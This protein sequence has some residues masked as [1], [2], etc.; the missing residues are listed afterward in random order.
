VNPLIYPLGDT[1]PLA[2]NLLQ[3]GFDRG[4][5]ERRQFSDGESYVR[6]ATPPEGRDV[7]LLCSL[8]GPDTKTLPLLFAADAAREQGAR[9]V[10]LAAPYLAYMR[11]DKA[12]HPGEAVTSQTYAKLLSAPFDWLV[13]L[14]PHLHRYPSLD[15]LYSIPAIA[16]SATQPIA[17]WVQQHVERPFLIGPDIESEQWVEA[18][19][20]LADAP[21]TVFH[22]TRKG[23]RD[24]SIEGT[25]API[26][27]GASPVIIDDIASSARTMI[28]AVRLLKG[29]NIPAPVCIA[30]HAL[31]A[32]DAFPKLHEAGPTVVVSTNSVAHP[33]NAIDIS[34]V[35]A[36][37]IQEALAASQAKP[38]PARRSPSAGSGS[39]ERVST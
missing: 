37:A 8:D 6:F 17:R 21:F 9:S 10:G 29:A 11:Q 20:R 4:E 33:S 23:D 2:A 18:I 35:L 34:T 25:R 1:H 39:V 16:A 38:N 24:V 13:T 31:F 36:D 14:D 5:I 19:A 22:K 7:V 28:E 30:V 3:L 32:G 26:P 12:F 27:A 15:A